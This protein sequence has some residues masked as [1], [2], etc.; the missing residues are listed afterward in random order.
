MLMTQR[1]Q[2]VLLR[3]YTASRFT[4]ARHTGARRVSLLKFFGFYG[5]AR[6]ASL[7]RRRW[8]R[9]TAPDGTARRHDE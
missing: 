3:Y 8:L 1:A 9:D 7:T 4:A 2:A 5:H 6:S